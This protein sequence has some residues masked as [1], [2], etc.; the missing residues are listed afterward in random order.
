MAQFLSLD[1]RASGPLAQDIMSL[2][3][4]AHSESLANTLL[5]PL[6][7]GEVHEIM[8]VDRDM[9]LVGVVTQTDLIAAFLTG[10]VLH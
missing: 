2:A 4:I 6:A 7:N 8:I 1:L 10:S 5:E 3:D 9:L